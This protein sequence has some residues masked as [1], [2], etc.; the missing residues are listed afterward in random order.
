MF[1][2]MMIEYRVTPVAGIPM[3]WLTEISHVKENEF[4]VDEQRVGPYAIWHHEHHFKDLGDGRVEMRD[5]ITY[6]PPFGLLGELVHPFLI[7][8]QLDRI[9]A[10][11]E[12][13]ANE[14]F[15]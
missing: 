10:H 7:K 15:G 13:A 2:G 8:P 5:K 9:F 1:A 14:L 11:R 3:T 6:V 4:F 12:K